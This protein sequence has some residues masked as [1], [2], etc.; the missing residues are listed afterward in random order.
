MYLTKEVQG[1]IYRYLLTEEI[2]LEITERA[3]LEAVS[4]GMLKN[5]AV[6]T[7]LFEVIVEA[8]LDDQSIETPGFPAEMVDLSNCWIC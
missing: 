3:I 4:I 1:L 6:G 2:P 8:L 7:P 5:S